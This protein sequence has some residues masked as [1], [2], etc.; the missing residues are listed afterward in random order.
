ME[1]LVE[2]ELNI[3]DGTSESKV[4]NTESAPISSEGQTH[5]V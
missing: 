2:L 4:E 3:P 1:C 5:A